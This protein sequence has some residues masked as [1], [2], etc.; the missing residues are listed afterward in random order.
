[1]ST[2][3]E[4]AWEIM[5]EAVGQTWTPR[6]ILKELQSSYEEDLTPR[7]AH[8]EAVIWED[9]YDMEPVEARR[10]AEAYLSYGP[11]LDREEFKELVDD[12]TY[13]E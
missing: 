11:D 7:E 3:S 4:D 6:R 9:D 12:W 8:E 10:F 13:R 5:D 1:M 2:T